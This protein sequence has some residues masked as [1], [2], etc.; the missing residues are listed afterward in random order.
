[1]SNTELEMGEYDLIVSM[2]DPSGRITYVNDIFCKFAEYDH[3]EVIGQPH[4]LVRHGDMPKAVF[5]L[6]WQRMKE[7]KP[8]FA[9]VKNKTKNDNYYWVK[10][11]VYPVVENGQLKHIVSY[12]KKIGD[13]AKQEVSRVYADLLMYE[14]SHTPGESLEHLVN[15]LADKGLTY[16]QMIDRLSLGQSL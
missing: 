9:F 2:T 5:Q 13:F 7:G 12:R 6:L 8:L 15:I 14:S 10:A 16:D 4:N 3:E 1:M 11:F